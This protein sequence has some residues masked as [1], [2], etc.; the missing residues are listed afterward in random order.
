MWF[1]LKEEESKPAGQKVSYWL[2][3]GINN[4]RSGF[5]TSVGKGK[6]RAKIQRRAELLLR[7]LYAFVGIWV[8]NMHVVCS[9]RFA[10]PLLQSRAACA[11]AVR[12]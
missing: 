5:D 3:P 6:G 11:P 1:E 10:F 4:G 9:I 7:R 12:L 8:D 2:I